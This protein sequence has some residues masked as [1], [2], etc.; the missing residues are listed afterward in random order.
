MAE[1]RKEQFEAVRNQVSRPHCGIKRK[2]KVERGSQEQLGT[3][4]SSWGQL[5]AGAV[6]LPVAYKVSSN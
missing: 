2:S 4:G 1:K 3:V 5:G 6:G